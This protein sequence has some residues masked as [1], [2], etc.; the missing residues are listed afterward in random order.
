MAKTKYNSEEWK[1]AAAE[2][3]DKVHQLIHDIGLNYVKDPGKIAEMLAFSANFYRY[4]V[5]NLSL[6]HHQNPQATYIQSFAAWKKMDAHV[7]KGEHGYNILVPVTITY[8]EVSEN[9]YVQYSYAT[10]EQQAKFKAG[11]LDGKTKLSY[12][13]GTVFDISQTD[14]PKEKYPE[15]F[16]MGYQS[17]EHSV[18]SDGLVRF[19]ESL[20]CP[21]IRDDLESIS[22]RGFYAPIEKK[23]VLNKLLE[24]TEVLSTLTHEIGH[25]LCDH[26][27]KNKNPLSTAQKEFEADCISII[28]QSHFN[29]D[30]TESR[31]KHLADHY[32]VFLKELKEN[33]P[34][35]SEE[36]VMDK[37][38]FILN[39]TL[40]IYRENIYDIDRYVDQAIYQ[41]VFESYN[42]EELP[43][44]ELS[45]TVIE[46][47]DLPAS[48]QRYEG[49]PTV[50]DALETM[51]SINNLD[52]ELNSS[53]LLTCD[54]NVDEVRP[55]HIPIYKNRK[56]DMETFDTYEVLEQYP[57]IAAEIKSALN[58]IEEKTNIMIMGNSKIIDAASIEEKKESV[59]SQLLM[60]R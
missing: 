14:Y 1:K 45:Y 23:I 33:N 32:N 29:L 20:K 54:F 49:L 9:K 17:E 59:L 40:R 5:N 15:L 60:A 27:N 4:S 13:I 48:G 51:D 58:V 57:Q 21:V 3:E 55:I 34:K 38:D 35:C 26:G 36:D 7:L 22:L 11:I 53:I 16:S 30:I 2:K 56:V 37:L 6:I 47:G 50:L 28:I 39:D 43:E 18:I 10:E 41:N 31:Q 42:N 8:I 46:C 25:F 12:K 52:G 24:D 44:P 19:C